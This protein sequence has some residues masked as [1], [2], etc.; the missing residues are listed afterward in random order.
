VRELQQASAPD[1]AML[2]VAV[3]ALGELLPRGLKA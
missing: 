1:L 3:R 2:A